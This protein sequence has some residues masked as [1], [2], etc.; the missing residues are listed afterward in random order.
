MNTPDKIDIP[1][2]IGMAMSEFR[3]RMNER[4]PESFGFKKNGCVFWGAKRGEYARLN[5]RIIFK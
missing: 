5:P 1:K 4:F 3:A 2:Y